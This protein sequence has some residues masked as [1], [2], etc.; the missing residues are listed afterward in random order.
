ME[1]MVPPMIGK[2]HL[3]AQGDPSK[4]PSLIRRWLGDRPCWRLVFV[5]NA[6]SKSVVALFPE[7]DIYVWR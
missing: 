3:V 4:T 7:A 2:I 5:E 1:R 6:E